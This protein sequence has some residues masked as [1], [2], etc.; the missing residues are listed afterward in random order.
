M[1]N[2]K[3]AKRLGATRLRIKQQQQEPLLL[4]EKLK[5]SK[6][7]LKKSDLFAKKCVYIGE[8]A[9]KPRKRMGKKTAQAQY[10]T[11]FFVYVIM[12]KRRSHSGA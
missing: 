10:L 4:T 5:F 6:K 12:K 7:F 8:G 9:K 2:E 1:R 11:V 3:F